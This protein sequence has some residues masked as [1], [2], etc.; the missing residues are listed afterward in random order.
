MQLT[1]LTKIQHW[2]LR[3]WVWNAE[4]N[5]NSR[6]PL[7][8]VCFFGLMLWLVAYHRVVVEM[9]RRAHRAT[10]FSNE[11]EKRRART[12]RKRDE[13][14]QSSGRA[15]VTQLVASVSWGQRE[16]WSRPEKKHSN[17]QDVLEAS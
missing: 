5:Q 1:K 4:R 16:A 3:T 7:L 10:N 12:S 15:Q 11:K 13:G 6:T 8:G 14:M 17:R 2:K 9:V